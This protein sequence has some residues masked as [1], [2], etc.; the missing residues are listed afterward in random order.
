MGGGGLTG[1]GEGGREGGGDGGHI[2]HM[3]SSIVAGTTLY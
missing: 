2:V 3:T 1:D